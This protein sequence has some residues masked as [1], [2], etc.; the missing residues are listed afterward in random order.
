[1]IVTTSKG[2]TFQDLKEYSAAR[3][4][5]VRKL[6]NGKFSIYPQ[7]TPSKLRHDRAE[8]R[9]AA[10]ADYY[11]SSCPVSVALAKF[12]IK[13]HHSLMPMREFLYR[14]FLYD[15]IHGNEFAQYIKNFSIASSASGKFERFNKKIP[16]LDFVPEI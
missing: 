8:I 10:L 5:S 11:I 14:T 6:A 13:E 7:S 15:L 2:F 9:A 1:M 4:L 16:Y 12:E 3:G